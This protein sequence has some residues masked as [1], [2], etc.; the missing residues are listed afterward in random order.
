MT[1]DPLLQV[2][3]EVLGVP[4]NELNDDTSPDNQAKWDS[5][6]SMELVA[7]IEE[8]F[9]IEMSTKEIMKSRSISLVREMLLG[10]NIETLPSD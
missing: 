10:K 4:L 3:H 5:M 1:A 9:D 2:F 7:A 6:R 8:T